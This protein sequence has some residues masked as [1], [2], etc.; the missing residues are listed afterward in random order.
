MEEEIEDFLK[1][2]YFLI[3]GF[4]SRPT[5]KSALKCGVKNLWAID[6]F[7]DLDSLELTKNINII[8]ESIYGKNSK[9]TIQDLFFV[10]FKE[11]IE[12]QKKISHVILTSGFDGRVDI[13]KK[14]KSFKGIIG[15]SPETIENVRDMSVLSKFCNEKQIKFPNHVD[16]GFNDKSFELTFPII[17]K[18]KSSGGGQNI[19]YFKNLEDFN[20]LKKNILPKSNF[21]AQEFIKGLDISA[22]ISC[23]GKNASVI[24]ITKQILGE[25]FL[26]AASNFLY[27]G[28]VIPF[29]V[30]DKIYEEIE[31]I[32]NEITKKFQLKGINGMD[33]ILT[34]DDLYLIEVNPRFPGTMELIESLLNKNLFY[35]HVKSSKFGKISQYNPRISK[36][37]IKFIVYAQKEFIVRDLKQIQGIHDIPRPGTHL[38]KGDPICS[39][40]LIGND[41]DAIWEDGVNKV[42]KIYDICN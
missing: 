10:K 16:L 36:I 14:I 34:D 9:N 30:N 2:G 1:S 5:I 41:L 8:S 24:A 18:P 12:E 15:N 11:I 6:Y 33:F 29:N 27:C 28:N 39:I 17:I 26:G 25:K 22:T 13:W 35:E 21:I 23:N 20:K 7:G 31:R 38:K 4:N 40:L 42:K 37:G 3:I 19:H 32:S